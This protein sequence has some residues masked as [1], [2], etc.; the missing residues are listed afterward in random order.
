MKKSNHYVD[1]KELEKHWAEWLDSGSQDAWEKLLVGV[2]KICQGVA[3]HF[4]PKNEEEY[5]ELVHETFTQT[6]E[7]IELGKLKFEPGKAP[8]FN[9]LTT[10]IMRQL[11]SLKNRE[12]RR[13]KI[14][15]KY[16]EK[17]IEEKCPE[18]RYV[19]QNKF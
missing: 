19:S 8:V 5:L 14:Y 4:K 11:Y 1:S 6:I 3:V 10:T 13:A 2:Y 15:S 9:L 7:K 17:V 16:R 18:I 12:S